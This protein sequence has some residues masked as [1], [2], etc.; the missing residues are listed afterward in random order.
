VKEINESGKRTPSATVVS[1][2]LPAA[3]AY[4]QVK[5]GRRVA[6]GDTA[7]RNS[8]ERKGWRARA[9]ESASRGRPTALTQTE[10][11]RMVAPHA[12]RH[13]PVISCLT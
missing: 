5:R 11:S 9:A 8:Q 12:Q 6:E 3:A 1:I 4:P 13:R 2:G 7:R 10:A